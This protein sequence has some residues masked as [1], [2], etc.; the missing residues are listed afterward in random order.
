MKKTLLATV[1]VLATGFSGALLADSHGKSGDRYEKH[2]Q[3]MT[4]K[5]ELSSEQQGQ[6]KG[7]HEKQREQRRALR[8]THQAEVNAIL[9]QEQQA[10]MAEMRAE[11]HEN[12][13]KHWEEGKKKH[14]HDDKDSN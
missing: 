8:E 9:T 1:M 13:K 6:L 2:M 4:E 5:L 10:K 12:M 3:Y 11:K 7:L 14:T